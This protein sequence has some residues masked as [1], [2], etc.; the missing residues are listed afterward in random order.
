M[1]SRSTK[2]DILDQKTN[3][4]CH[5]CKKYYISA[6]SLWN[7][8]NKFHKELKSVQQSQNNAITKEIEVQETILKSYL[9]NI[10]DKEFG[11]KKDLNEHTK[12]H[13]IKK[14]MS[15]NFLEN[16]KLVQL[17]KANFND[18]DNELFKLSFN[19]FNKNYNNQ[20]DFIV[21]FED[22]YKWIGFTQKVNAKRLLL[23]NF[24]QDEDYILFFSKE[25]KSFGRPIEKILLK[26][27]SFKKFCLK[28]STREADKIYNYYI[29]MEELVF[30]YIRE[31]YQEQNIIVNS[32]L[33]ELEIKNKDLNYKDKIIKELQN[34]LINYTPCK[35]EEIETK[36][37]VYVFSTDIEGIYKVGE[38]K[39]VSRRKKELQTSCIKDINVLMEFKTFNSQILENIIH[40]IL[41]RYRCNSIREHFKAELE[42]IKTLI[43]IAGICLNTLKSSYQDISK[44][45]LI[46]KV[47]DKLKEVK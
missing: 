7:H 11:N 25:E 42:Y 31:K 27:N 20:N 1:V 47:L 30:K 34:K 23:N 43:N 32:A 17:I 38:S 46:D 36:Q 39:D 45:E 4:L 33:E 8:K 12:T 5:V 28:A 24:I 10:C 19:L 26:V 3:F 41:E 44:E 16:D 37:S 21:D 6:N 2:S 9:C 13:T 35:Y 18:S 15:S 29:K 22:I 40:N 14:N